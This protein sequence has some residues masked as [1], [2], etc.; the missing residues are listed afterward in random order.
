MTRFLAIGV[1][2]C[3][4]GVSG[5]AEDADATGGVFDDGT[6]EQPCSG[7]GGGFDEVGGQ[8]GMCLAA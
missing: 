6:D 8:Q 7:Q 3:C 1:V 2:P 5:G 4:G